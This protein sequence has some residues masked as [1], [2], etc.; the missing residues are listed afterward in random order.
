V[1]PRRGFGRSG[2]SLS[3]F[4]FG[5]MRLVAARFDLASATALVTRL[6]DA[7]VTSF[8]VSAEYESH[9]L[10]CAA[11]K[12]LRRDRPAAEIE[13]VSKIPVPHF[14][15]N[16]FDPE[17]AVALIE[18]DRAAL[19]VDRIDVVQWMIRHTPNEDAPRLAILARDGAAA[20]DAWS[21]LKAD[22]RIGALAVFPYS[23][24]LLRASLD[25]PWV[26]GLVTYLNPVEL[27][28]A[29]YL[30]RLAEE[31]RGLAAIRPLAAGKALE[32]ARLSD[33]LDVAPEDR[34][35]FALA[36]SLMH[37]AVAS[38]ILTVSSA[39]HVSA[40]LHAIERVEIDRERFT[41]LVRHFEAAR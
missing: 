4:C 18:A 30:D 17:R 26:D 36:F 40:A 32:D 25:L 7:G 1:I 38:S 13:I 28:A 29:P 12:A 8:H 23:D 34:A 27:E 14:S 9:A 31:G 15:E 5:T 37:P 3:A 41:A 19:G 24:A 33:G 2:V 22:G 39:E 11:L 10:A 16:R 21:G 35:A 20:E 6:F